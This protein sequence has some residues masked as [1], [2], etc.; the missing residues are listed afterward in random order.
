MPGSG[1]TASN[2]NLISSPADTYTSSISDLTNTLQSLA[3]QFCG[4]RVHVKKIVNGQPT[5]GWTF[6]GA[7]Q[8]A[9]CHDRLPE[10]HPGDRR[11]WQPR[12]ARCRST[13]TTSTPGGGA[14]VTATETVQP[15]YSF[16]SGDCR[17][18]GYDGPIAAGQVWRTASRASRW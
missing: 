1:I 11:Q 7:T 6:T 9:A 18:G 17:T 15:G 8:R 5:N 2:L 16:V 12:S 3:N 4:A 14:N 13:S 10:Q